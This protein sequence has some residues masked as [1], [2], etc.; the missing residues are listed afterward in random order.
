MSMLGNR[1]LTNRNNILLNADDLLKLMN[2]KENTINV[3]SI[4]M[5]LKRCIFNNF[6]YQTF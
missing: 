1:S 2:V 5:Y 3:L 6:S 4:F